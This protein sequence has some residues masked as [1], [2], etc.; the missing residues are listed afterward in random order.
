K[1][2]NIWSWI[3]TKYLT[4]SNWSTLLVANNNNSSN[5]IWFFFH[6]QN[7]FPYSRKL[8]S[9]WENL[10]QYAINWSKYIKIGAYDCT[11][12]SL[13]MNDI[14][15]DKNY[16]HWTIY[17]PLTNTTQLAFQAEQILDNIIFENI[18]IHLFDKLNK[19]INQCYGKSW[20]IE[21]IIE[22]KTIDDLNKLIPTNLN[23]FQLFVSDDILLYT[24]VN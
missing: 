1:D 4:R 17:C 18:L 6:Y 9:I 8:A 14:C 15:Q 22:P 20:P 11:N 2:N 24:I 3:K 12:E 13:L 5:S 23:K 19:I 16:S 21:N 10:A 7:S